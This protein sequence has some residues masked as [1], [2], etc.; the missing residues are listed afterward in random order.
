MTNSSAVGTTTERG[1]RVLLAVGVLVA[2]VQAAQAASCPSV[3][4]A[5]FYYPQNPAIGQTV[6]AQIDLT[7]DFIHV[8]TGD[9]RGFIEVT[10]GTAGAPNDHLYAGVRDTG[11]GHGPQVYFEFDGTIYSGSN[12]YVPY[13]TSVHVWISHD[14]ASQ[15]S[16]HWSGTQPLNVITYNEGNARQTNFYAV[17]NHTGTTKNQFEYAFTG[18][19][20]WSVDSLNGPCS[21]SGYKATRQPGVGFVTG[22]NN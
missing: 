11:N 21:T 20:P 7:S 2:P 12:W 18:L 16:A 6:N 22:D 5:G 1:L 4:G 17:D 3:T 9:I 13:N 8:Y 14:G 15:Y 10:I 19:G